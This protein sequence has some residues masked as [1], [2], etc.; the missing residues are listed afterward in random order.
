MQ[1]YKVCQLKGLPNLRFVILFLVCC[2][3]GFCSLTA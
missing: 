3:F 1:V 2:Y